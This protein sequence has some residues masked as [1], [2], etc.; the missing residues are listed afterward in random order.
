MTPMNKNQVHCY[1]QTYLKVKN[2]QLFFKV[3]VGG[4]GRLNVNCDCD[5]SDG[6]GVYSD[7]YQTA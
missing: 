7:E 4:K 3:I 2:W 5:H 6:G 1:G